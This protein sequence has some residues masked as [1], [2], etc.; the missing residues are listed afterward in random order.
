MLTFGEAFARILKQRQ[1]SISAAAAELGF[2]SKTALF[3]IINDES[4]PSSIRKCLDAAIACEALAL[5]A[6]E[7]AGLET[8]LKVS[9]VGKHAYMIVSVLDSILH[10]DMSIPEDTNLCGNTP[11]TTMSGFCARTVRCIGSVLPWESEKTR[12]FIKSFSLLALRLN[13]MYR[14]ENEEGYPLQDMKAFL[15][16]RDGEKL[17]ALASKPEAKQLGSLID[18]AEAEKAARACDVAAMRAM[19]QKIIGTAEGKKLMEGLKK[20]MEK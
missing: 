10:T 9:A 8:A 5:T 20:A 12:S 15:E 3:R 11:C 6:Q 19:M 2:S 14:D 13:T 4:K 7:I 16:G 1:M 17:R 18:P